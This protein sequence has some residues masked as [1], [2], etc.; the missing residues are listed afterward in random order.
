MATFT[1]FAY[2]SN[3]LLERLRHS[4]RCPTAVQVS[5][6][7][8][9]GYTIAFHK[10]SD[11]DG[12]GKATLRP[13]PGGIVHGVLY[14][15]DE[16]EHAALDRAEGVGNGYDR[17]NDFAVISDGVPR[18]AATYIV[19]ASHIDTDVIPFDWYRALVVA[20]ARQH[21]LPADYIARLA[22]VAT[23]SDD[24]LQRR[25]RLNAIEA[26]RQAGR[27]DLA[28]ALAKPG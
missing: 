20:G 26:L 2:G 5:T 17:L 27:H 14:E 19:A 6:A 24:D 16:R 28:D 9:T 8:V 22:S 23:T 21:G 25:E 15:I 4:Q 7:S 11:R 1:Y 12:S 18:A 13:D 3:M 10:R